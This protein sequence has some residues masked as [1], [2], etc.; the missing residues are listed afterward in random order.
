MTEVKA[1]LVFGGIARGWTGGTGSIQAAVLA[2]ARNW[3]VGIMA[4]TWP[5]M[6]PPLWEGMERAAAQKDASKAWTWAVVGLL[7]G[8]MPAMVWATGATMVENILV[9]RRGKC[10]GNQLF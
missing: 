8:A 10:K 3:A 6:P 2:I 9:W 5:R 7:P 1:A 4:P